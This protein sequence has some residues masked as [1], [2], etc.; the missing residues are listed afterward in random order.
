M[1]TYHYEC[2]G[3]KSRFERRHPH[4][5]IPKHDGRDACIYCKGV[6]RYVFGVPAVV[7]TD[8]AYAADVGTGLENVGPFRRKQILAAARRAGISPESAVYCP[9]LCAPG[10]PLD[11]AAFVPHNGA[12]SHIKR[13]CEELNYGCEGA[14]NVRRREPESDPDD[15]PYRPAPDVIEQE[16]ESIVLR[17]HGGTVTKKKYDDLTEAA[18]EKLSGTL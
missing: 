4:Q 17:E 7:G 18:A 3:C 2:E 8:T 13:R 12:K 6:L 10:K 5:D 16:V 14:V 1:P 15:K 9:S 11:P